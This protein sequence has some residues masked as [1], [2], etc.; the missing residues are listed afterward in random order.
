MFYSNFI[1]TD[2]LFFNQSHGRVDRATRSVAVDSGS[3]RSLV[4]SIT[5]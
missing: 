2:F 3:I 1:L 5:E 4:K